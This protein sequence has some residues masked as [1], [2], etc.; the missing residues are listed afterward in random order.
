MIE[1]LQAVK[2]YL[3]LTF[4]NED[5]L[6]D[7]VF[8]AAEICKT[9]ISS[10]TFI[11]DKRQYPVIGLGPVVESSCEIAFCNKTI[12]QDNLLEVTDAITDPRF[13]D[14]PLVT[15]SPYI[16][17]Y[18]GM[19][20]VT[21]QG[22]TIGTLCVIDM[23]PKQLNDEQKRSLRILAKQVM[24]RLE[25]KKNIKLLRD[26]IE[27]AKRN[28]QLLEQAEVMEKTFYNNS[29]DYFLLLN[30][31]NEIVAYNTAAEELFSRYGKRI[32]KGRKLLDYLLPSSI[33]TFNK[34]LLKAKQGEC[35][36]FEFLMNEP[37]DNQ[38]W[39]K[40]HLNPTYNSTN[41]FIG[42]AC[43]GCNIDNDKRLQIRI[44]QQKTTL[45]QIARL[46]SHD[47]RHP[48]TNIMGIVNLIKQE[49]Y[50]FNK[51][52]IEYLDTA[53]QEL[54]TVIKKIVME[55]HEAV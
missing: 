37:A 15:G 35:V 50:Q 12:Q 16:R 5:E 29:G 3:E 13:F 34:Y 39:C 4:D 55:S 44:E 14:N 42:I 7:L 22:L 47:I 51:Q 9:S 19:P 21:S 49:S 20:L 8:L 11:D 1:R 26:S 10:I 18:A 45:T 36:Y 27:E 31:S 41:E 48:L 32:R 2:E 6:Q 23:Q 33:E 30:T 54:D 17:F 38:S 28:A 40:I 24:Q 53:S 25:T 43:L 46:H 52:Y